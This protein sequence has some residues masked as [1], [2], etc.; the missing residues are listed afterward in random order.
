MLPESDYRFERELAEWF[1]RRAGAWSGTAS[2][3]LASL[4]SK[5]SQT[6]ASVPNSSDGLYAYLQSHRQVLQSLGVDVLLL[7]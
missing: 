5:V 6:I 2:E 3:L 7:R 4:R 1:S